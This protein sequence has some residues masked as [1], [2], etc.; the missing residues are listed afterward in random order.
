MTL[1]SELLMELIIEVGEVLSLGAAPAGERRVVGILGGTFVG[2]ELRGEVLPGGADWQLARRD[3]VV[4]VDAHYALR[5]AGGGII[6]VLSQG[7][8]HSPSAVLEALA[9]GEAV[10]PEAYFFHTFMRFETGAPHLEWLNGTMAVS[11]G[12]RQARRV[13][14]RADRLL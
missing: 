5:E 8:R 9:R 12:E 6:R 7:Y 11:T 14:L 1:R 13:L 2:P 4:E 3:G 10:D